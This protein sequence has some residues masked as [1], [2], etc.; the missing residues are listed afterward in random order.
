MVQFVI[1]FHGTC[2][3]EPIVLAKTG[4]LLEK[5]LKKTLP[6]GAFKN[7]NPEHSLKMSKIRGRGNQSTEVKLKMHLVRQGIV[8]WKM[9]QKMGKS[10]PDFVFPS[11]KLVVFIDGCFWHGCPICGRIP[12]TNKAYWKKKIELNKERDR[13]NSRAIRRLGYRVI[14]I[15]EHQI[16]RD[17]K[18]PLARIQSALE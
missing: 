16:Q 12:K 6:G 13:R 4:N 5:K 11:E 15:W 2:G 18:R 1:L 9:H 14:R 3:N 10:R 8:G 17:V 7:V